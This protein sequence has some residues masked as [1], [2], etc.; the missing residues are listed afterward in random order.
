MVEESK[1][2]DLSGVIGKQSDVEIDSKIQAAISEGVRLRPNQPIVTKQQPCT[3]HA[4][5]YRRAFSL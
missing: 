2:P 3:P 1:Q 5:L 4:V